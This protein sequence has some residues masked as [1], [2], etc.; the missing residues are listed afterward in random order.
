MELAD[1]VALARREERVL[2]FAYYGKARVVLPH[3]V[4]STRLW[5]ECC[6]RRDIRTFRLERIESVAIGPKV[7][8]VGP[9]EDSEPP[10]VDNVGGG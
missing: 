9:F 2:I 5:C 1:T 7:E 3:F 8:D 10:V 6:H 4:D